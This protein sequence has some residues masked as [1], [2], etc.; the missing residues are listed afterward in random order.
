[1]PRTTRVGSVGDSE[2]GSPEVEIAMTGN[3]AHPL[4]DTFGEDG[5]PKA[6]GSVCPRPCSRVSQR[7]NLTNQ[8]PVSCPE[9]PFGKIS[10]LEAA[11]REGS[12]ERSKN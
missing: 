3:K 12:Y 11:T 5:D 1:V 8:E 2:C 10:G 9:R 4:P 6:G 7:G